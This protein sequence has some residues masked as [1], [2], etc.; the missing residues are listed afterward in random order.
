MASG[1]AFLEST[2]TQNF[3][4]KTGKVLGT[5]ACQ[6]LSNYFQ[7]MPDFTERIFNVSREQWQVG[8][9]FLEPFIPLC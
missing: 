8:L 5:R 6:S 9:A 7:N 3:R 4:T 1:L 2:G